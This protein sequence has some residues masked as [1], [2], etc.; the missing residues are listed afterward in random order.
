MIW[1]CTVNNAYTQVEE[2]KFDPELKL[3]YHTASS[4]FPWPVK[5]KYYFCIT[6]KEPG[7]D[8][9]SKIGTVY[10]SS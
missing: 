3:P 6:E 8:K 10:L 7:E 5:Q 2:Q 9:L 4:P 1:A